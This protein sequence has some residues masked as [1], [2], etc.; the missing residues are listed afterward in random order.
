MSAAWPDAADGADLAVIARREGVV[1]DYLRPRQGGGPQ[2]LLQLGRGV[3]PV[4]ARSR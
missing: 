1:L 3:S 4:R 2:H